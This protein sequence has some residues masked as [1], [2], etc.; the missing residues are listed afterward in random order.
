[1]N[2]YIL[3]H[4]INITNLSRK[5]KQDYTASELTV[6]TLEKFPYNNTGFSV[7]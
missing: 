6:V 1:M 3:Y 2:K 5:N 4:V 7:Q